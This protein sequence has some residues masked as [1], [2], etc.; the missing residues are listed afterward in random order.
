[1]RA[2]YVVHIFTASLA[3]LSGFVALYS[4]KGSTL[5]RKS[6]TLFVYTMVTMAILGMTLAIGRNKA[7]DTNVPAGLFT[8]YLVITSLTT[9]RPPREWKRIHIGAMLVMLVVGVTDVSFGLQALAGARSSWQAIPFLLFGSIGLLAVAGD[10]RI[11]RT[12]PLTGAR[13]L[14]RHLWRMS[15]ALLFATLSFVVQLPKFLPKQYQIPGLL[16]LPL[17]TV[18]VTML[19]WLWR[20]RVRRRLG[21]IVVVGVPQPAR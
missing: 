18:F 11:L 19:Y 12:G 2:I 1:M 7:P 13:R 4:P 5:H 16:M 17:L 3:L 21:G 8:S 20:V 6:G 10:A 14:A 15:F 9:V